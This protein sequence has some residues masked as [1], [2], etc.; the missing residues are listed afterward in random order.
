MRLLTLPTLPYSSPS[1]GFASG[2]PAVWIEHPVHSA[3]TV[4]PCLP[5]PSIPPL[6]SH[7][8]QWKWFV[9]CSQRQS[10]ALSRGQARTD[11]CR[12]RSTAGEGSV[13][14][15]P[16]ATASR[17]L[18]SAETTARGQWTRRCSCDGQTARLACACATDSTQL[19]AQ[20][21]TWRAIIALVIAVGATE[22]HSSAQ[23][24]LEGRHWTVTQWWVWSVGVWLQ[25]PVQVNSHRMFS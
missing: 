12:E 24:T 9:V 13:S 23:V 7:C 25:G 6:P 17:R 3:R 18:L 22:R 1:A 14:G 5:P 15:L 11:Q 8:S 16:A 19:L 21:L 4:N 10:V 20:S 2:S